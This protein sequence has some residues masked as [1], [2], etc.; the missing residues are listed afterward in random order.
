[1][2][3]NLRARH[4]AWG[5]L[6]LA[7]AGAARTHA[8]PASPNPVQLLTEMEQ[9]LVPATTQLARVRV[10]VHKNDASAATKAWEA[11]V[12]RRRFADGPRTAITLR[13]YGIH[14]TA[15]SAVTSIR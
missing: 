15:V 14:I 13:M 9:A 5:V 1:M 7:L 12:A 2:T 4:K 3:M 10:A 11:L 8:E 6:L